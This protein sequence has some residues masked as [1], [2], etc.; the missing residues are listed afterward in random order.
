MHVVAHENLV[1]SRRLLSTKMKT[2]RTRKELLVTSG[3]TNVRGLGI[4]YVSSSHSN[5]SICVTELMVPV[6]L[7]F[8]VPC[9]IRYR[10]DVCIDASDRLVGFHVASFNEHALTGSWLLRYAF[11]NVVTSAPADDGHE[12][13][14]FIGQSA[15][16]MWMRVVSSW[17]CILLYTWSLL[18]PVLMPDRCV[19][20]IGFSGSYLIL[21]NNL[22]IRFGDY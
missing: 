8:M 12:D 15:V 19:F 11:R 6:L 16:A 2:K 22:A 5:H 10:G 20:P 14:V 9:Y 18:A 7:V 1:P 13:D 4:M 3:M 17:I 21:F